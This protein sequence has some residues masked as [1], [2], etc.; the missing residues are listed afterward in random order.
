MGYAGT[1]GARIP[2]VNP[3]PCDPTFDAN[4]L[5][6]HFDG[7]FA[8]SSQY[9]RAPTVLNGATI[10]TF[11]SV[12]GTGSGAFTGGVAPSSE[13][14]YGGFTIDAADDFTIEHWVYPTSTT[15]GQVVWRF[16]TGGAPFFYE[17]MNIV[18]GEARFSWNV[19]GVNFSEAGSHPLDQWYYIALSRVA[20]IARGYVGQPGGDATLAGSGASAS[21]IANLSFKL[22]SANVSIGSGFVGDIDEL[23]IKLLGLY[24]ATNFA[25]PDA[26]F[27]DR[28]C[29]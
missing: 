24:D 13:V 5:L 11:N 7:S 28:Q 16:D 15:N 17:G 19:L 25:V 3:S 4:L 6:L 22:A 20:G 12:F 18:G 9:D 8:D 21:G 29:T 1:S 2:H 10:D 23:R 27:A 14:D 26:P